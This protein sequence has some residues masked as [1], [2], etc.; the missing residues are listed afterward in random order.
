VKLW[1]DAHREPE[2][3]WVW[4]KTAHCALVLLGGGCVEKISLAPDQPSVTGPVTDWMINTGSPSRCTTHTTGCGVKK[5]R[6][7]RIPP[8]KIPKTSRV[9]P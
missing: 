6:L 9:S 8:P 2:L 3:D 5:S 7:I 1:L 4:A